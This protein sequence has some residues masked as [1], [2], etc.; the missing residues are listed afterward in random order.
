MG[1][2]AQSQ[3]RDTLDWTR[4]YALQYD[5]SELVHGLSEL[6][7]KVFEVSMCLNAHGFPPIGLGSRICIHAYKHVYRHTDTIAYIRSLGFVYVF[8]IFL[9]IRD[10]LVHLL[11]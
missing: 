10:M 7:R 6:P 3:T 4:F 11:M 5:A 8:L 9:A 1:N 2:H